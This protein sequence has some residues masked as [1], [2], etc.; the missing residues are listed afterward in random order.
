[1]SLNELASSGDVFNARDLAT[2]E[3][4]NRFIAPSAFGRLL[5]DAHCI[6]E[7][8]R[9]SGKTTMLRM[10]TPEAFAIWHESSQTEVI[11]FI[12][13]FVPADIRW[14][15]QL[16]AR[17][18]DVESITARETVQQAAF[19]VAV[20]LAFIE[21]IEQCR[22]LYSQ[23]GKT[24]PKLF[25][26]LDRKIEAELVSAV[27]SL[28][29]IEIGVPSFNGLKLALRRRQ[30]ELSAI[31]LR[32]AEGSLLSQ[33]LVK[34]SFLSSTWLDNINTA[35]ETANDVLARPNQRWAILLD[36]LEIVPNSLLR[37]IAD[38]L[39][40]T[41]NLLRFK[42]A[43][44]PTGSDLISYSETGASS[45]TDDYRPVKLWH[46]STREA[47]IFSEK[48]FS[49]ALTRLTGNNESS[50]NISEILG[51][52]S[53]ESNRASPD[54]SINRDDLSTYSVITEEISASHKARIASFKSLYDKDESFRQLL[55]NKG[56]DPNSPPISDLN[57]NGTLVRKITPLV[58]HRDQ[59]LTSF[60]Y[61]TGPKRKGGR[62]GNRPY[63]GYPNLVDLTEGNPRW[64]LTLTEALH[65]Q[66]STSFQKIS[67]AS[68]Q[69]LAITDFVQQF[70]SKLTVYPTKS[71]AGHRWTP[72][73]FMEA[74]G[75][76]IEHQIYG[77]AFSADPAMSFTLDERAIKNYGEYIRTC[78]DLGALVIMRK[79]SAAPLNSGGD[80][81]SLLNARVR[82]S[83]RLA[84][85]FRLPLR[86]TR[87]QAVSTALKTGELLIDPAEKIQRSAAE[88]STTGGQPS[89]QRLPL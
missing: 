45:P 88:E 50:T 48:L 38:A 20:N 9:G 89:Q 15:K 62:K 75:K 37:S 68:V 2:E 51:A 53:W 55:D 14:A 28:W 32:L 63:H 85:H 35:I 3:V 33:E 22:R 60:S 7:G 6:M 1:M 83:Y 52:S 78:I 40:S 44:S 39:R 34:N 77:S 69:T 21:T 5:S 24:Y 13:I 76:S 64:I 70:L 57:T 16:D 87:E 74:L 66:S 25:I 71:S 54:D 59:E 81:S 8:P 72:R 73:Q 41:S 26:E 19:S 36:E 23:H 61:A 29:Q 86:S 80:G 10:L 46:T 58:F 42:L 56:I 17:L 30:H 27:A 4:A 18:S 79:D 47:R 49:A 82:I 31:A 43:L 67:A 84:P 65:A 11:G 12:G